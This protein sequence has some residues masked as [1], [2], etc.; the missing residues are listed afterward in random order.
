M[1]A[2]PSTIALALVLVILLTVA[3]VGVAVLILLNRFREKSVPSAASGSGQGV[4]NPPPTQPIPRQCPQC[5]AQLKPDVPEGLCPA[6]LLQRGIATEGGAP[7]QSTPFTAPPL[8]EVAKLFPQL[9]ILEVI[10]HGGMGAVYKAR[11][12]ALERLVALKI[13]TPRSGGDLDFAGRF[14]REARALARLSHPN[15]VGVYDFGQVRRSSAPSDETGQPGEPAVLNYFIM[16]YVDGSNLRQVEQAGKLTPRE[17]LQI[18]PQICAAL[19]FAHD[20]GIVH[21]DIKPENVLLD[22][23]GRVKI[24]DFGLAKILGQQPDLRLT[25]ARDV[26]GTPHY[27]APEQVEKPQEVDHRADIY[28]L[29]VVF[30]EMLTGELPLGK[31]DPPSHKVHVDVR[32]DEVVLRSLAKSPERRYQHV[33]EVSTEL[34][35]IAHNP[36]SATPPVAPISPWLSQQGFDY[37]SKATLFGLPLVH[38]TAGMDPLTGKVRVSKGIIAIGGRAHGVIAIGGFAMGGMAIGGAAVGVIAMGGGALGILSFGGLAIALLLALGGGAIAPV[39]IGGAAVGYMVFG[40]GGFGAHVLAGN[41]Q[42]PVAQQFF[43]H[44]GHALVDNVQLINAIIVIVALGFG[45]GLPLWIRK[46]IQSKDTPRVLERVQA[47]LAIMDAG[48]YGR[49]WENASPYFQRAV[50]REE[51]IGKGEKIRRPLAAVLSR[52][53]RVGVFTGNGTRFV[54][55]FDTDFDGMH[56]TVETVTFTLQSNGDWRAVGYLIKPASE[57]N[58]GWPLPVAVGTLLIA[59]FICGAFVIAFP[60]Q[61]LAPMIVMGISAGALII[62]LAYWIKLAA[63]GNSRRWLWPGVAMAVFAAGLFLFLVNLMNSR[64][65]GE[66]A[67]ERRVNRLVTDFPEAP[68]FSKPESTYAAWARAAA[69]MDANALNRMQL[70]PPGPQRYLDWFTREQER[71]IVGTTVYGQAKILAVQT[72]RGDLAN[73]IAEVPHPASAH[74]GRYSSVILVRNNGVWKDFTEQLFP[75]LTSAKK[76]FNDEKGMWQQMVDGSFSAEASTGNVP[77]SVFPSASSASA[78]RPEDKFFAEQPP[79]VVE[80]YPATGAQD[81]APGV[82]EI[83]VRFSK[84]MADGSW[85]WAT[86]WEDSTPESI[87]A[88]HFLADGR[89][90]IMKVRLEPGKTYAWWLNSDKFKNF[91]DQ[92]GRPAV[93][94]L[95]T[96]QT[97]SK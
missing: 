77:T 22:K 72:W 78:P 43:G 29:G 30:Y 17:A 19:Q 26:M 67:A 51:W 52:R 45:V 65:S 12:P 54:A 71:D 20:E 46:R 49:S 60:R 3:A 79:V 76:T 8:A 73:V 27:M 14:T 28:S 18:I 23:K 41:M 9:E 57:E 62:C 70:N 32:L 59:F 75:S 4:G 16:E 93:P 24:A 97:Q 31:F 87:D 89:T 55:K 95:L 48:N 6:C 88:P 84:A 68:D 66:L 53:F 5:G 35:N 50:S 21:R 38:I 90:C 1:L 94:Y 86:A 36:G 39:A 47:W 15:I 37:K 83:R 11:Q 69:R 82:T 34:E 33:S 61:A 63:A 91:K 2:E 64:I 25:G 96:F 74:L 42:D 58:S 92:G 44:W 56:A 10:G 85:S 7:A 81:V 13:L 80:T 40:G